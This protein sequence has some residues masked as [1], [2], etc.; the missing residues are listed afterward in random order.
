MP[1]I[2]SKLPRRLAVVGVAVGLGLLAASWYIG[3]YNPLHLPTTWEQWRKMGEPPAPVLLS[4][5]Q[6]AAVAL[7]PGLLLGFFTED[8]GATA[9]LVMWAVGAALNGVLYY[10]LGRGIVAVRER[11]R[12]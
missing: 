2:T 5:L 3:K 11:F 9:N 4:L 6:D 12:R 7:C 10:W 1:M 8:M